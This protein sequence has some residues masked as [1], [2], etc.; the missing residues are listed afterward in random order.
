VGCDHALSGK[1]SKV[2]HWAALRKG[3]FPPV[4]AYHAA[5]TI[6]MEDDNRSYSFAFSNA[7]PENLEG[8]GALYCQEGTPPFSNWFA[9]GDSSDNGWGILDSQPPGKDPSAKNLMAVATAWASSHP[10]YSINACELGCIGVADCQ[11]TAS[12]LFHDVSGKYPKLA[13]E[14]MDPNCYRATPH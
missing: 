11:C 10:L 5:V 9:N 12:W 8:P 7:I 3:G 13:P 4:E 2:E 14:H 1:I 6:H